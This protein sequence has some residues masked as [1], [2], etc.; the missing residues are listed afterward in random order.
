MSNSKSITSFYSDKFRSISKRKIALFIFTL[1]LLIGFFVPEPKFIP[2]SGASKNDWNKDSFWFEPWGASIT[3]KGI[4][5]FGD[6][7][8]PLLA[9][10]HL[11]IIYTGELS[12]G[13]K[14]IIGLGP[15]WRLHYFAHLDSI[16]VNSGNTVKAGTVI[17]AI[18]DTGNALGKPAHLHYSIVTL[19]PYIWK[20]D[21]S[22]QGYKKAFYLNPQNYL[23][24][25]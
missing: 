24:N 6:K 19:L 10:S 7:G 9:S 12:R 11:L 14:I 4:D 22:T 20:I 1:F 23:L 5:I 2:V 3:H 8:T 25:Q 13:G 16:S 21:N 17:G 15:K 18:G